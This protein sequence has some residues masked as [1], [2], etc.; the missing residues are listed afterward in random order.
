MSSVRVSVLSV[1]VVGSLIGV[2]ASTGTAHAD[3]DYFQLRSDA[4]V[5]PARHR[6]RHQAWFDFGLV[7]S[8]ITAT[9]IGAANTSDTIVADTVHF[10]INFKLTPHFYLGWRY[11]RLGTIS[12]AVGSPAVGGRSSSGTQVMSVDSAI[13]G[14]T[15]AVRAVAG[16]I[17][18]SG[19]LT[20]AA[21]LAAGARIETTDGT[22]FVG[23]QAQEDKLFEARGRL[24]L[25]L[26]RGITVGA[27]AGVNML[28][29]REVAIGLTVGL[30]MYAWGNQR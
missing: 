8:Q 13:H 5:A 25:W 27:V 12:D 21:E 24:A 18:G 20:G 26:S 22:S 17:T 16:L 7:R 14:S 28:D 15:G 3:D 11:R 4:P 23:E 19:G 6:A 2:A 10:G 30:H 1:V 9:T 29:H